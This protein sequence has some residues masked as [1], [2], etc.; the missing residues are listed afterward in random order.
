VEPLGEFEVR[1]FA[2][3]FEIFAVSRPIGAPEEQVVT[4]YQVH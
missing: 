1:G 4:T 3:L 2:E